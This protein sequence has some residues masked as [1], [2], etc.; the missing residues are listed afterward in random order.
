L[1]TSKFEGKSVGGQKH[2]KVQSPFFSRLTKQKV[3]QRCYKIRVCIKKLW[4]S[5]CSWA[6]K[7][8]F[9]HPM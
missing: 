9:V 5:H 6:V 8:R 2:R 4:N 7:I 3:T 1:K